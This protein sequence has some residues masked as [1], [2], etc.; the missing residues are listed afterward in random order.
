MDISAILSPIITIGG[1]GLLFGVGLGIAAKKFA[2]PVDER[3]EQ[4]K[5]NLPGANC[6]GCGFAGCEAMAKSI[7]SGESKVNAC[8]VCNETQIQ[9]IAEVMGMQADKK[10]KK[11][12]VVRCKGNLENAKQKFDYTGLTTCEDAHL[13]GGGPKMCSYGCLG[14][15]SCVTQCQF[16]AMQMI[17]GLP[18]IDRN[19]CVGCGACERQ[20]PR[21]I[22]HL[23]PVHSSYHVDCVSKDKGKEVKEGCKVGCIGCGICVKQCESQA[24]TL[25]ENCAQ[26]NS[27]LCTTCGKCSMKCPTHAISNLLD[28]IGRQ[29][30]PLSASNPSKHEQISL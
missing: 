8:P 26:I 16:D 10:D 4:I 3:V 12:A 1:M 29:K 19:K 20:C 7:V 2:V 14:Y 25:K 9:A 22:I 18:I 30:L 5:E 21:Q 15:G 11:I 6:G 13:I 24:I 17:D 23:M 28:E 27:N